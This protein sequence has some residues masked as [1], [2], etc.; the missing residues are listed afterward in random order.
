MTL[1]AHAPQP[2]RAL[3]RLLISLCLVALLL[4]AA[5]SAADPSDAVILGYAL[6]MLE[7][8][9]RLTDAQVTVRQGAV[10]VYVDSFGG[11]PPDLV[12][13]A[14]REI[15][16]VTRVALS[17][18]GSRS[19]DEAG[20]TGSVSPTPSK[21]FP[22][23]LLIAPFH[24]DPRWPHFSGAVRF[25]DN[26]KPFETVFAGNFGETFAVYRDAAPGGGHWEVSI[27]AG[28]FSL[29]DLKA[30]NKDMINADYRVG[31]LTAYRNGDLSGFLRLY[32]Q[33]SHLG[34]EFLLAQDIA[35]VNR[36]YEE[37]DLKISYNVTTWL[38]AYGGGGLLVRRDPQAL[39]PWT[40]Q[41]GLELVSPKAYFGGWLRPVAFGDFQTH[42]QN[43]WTTSVSLMTGVQIDPIHIGGRRIQLLAE[44]YSGLSPNGQ[45]YLTE[46]VQWMGFGVHLYF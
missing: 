6:S 25:S 34:D 39:R 8:E 13:R 26:T 30:E 9:F 43:N 11:V 16:G 42:Q 22:P 17:P 4:P 24:A 2:V 46:R 28:V 35:R 20:V 14:L 32:H 41:Y 44:Y 27:Q 45:F 33:S 1:R 36:S 29:F 31:M 5:A 12:T 40:T 15:P 38:R 3:A 21:L 7:R 10:T 37:V 18:G 19:S 23:G